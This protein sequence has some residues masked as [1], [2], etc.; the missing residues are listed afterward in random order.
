MD[1]FEEKLESGVKCSQSTSSKSLI[2][3]ISTGFNECGK[4]DIEPSNSE[5]ISENFTIKI[6]R[7]CSE[8]DIKINEN[9]IP[10]YSKL[11]ISK[12]KDS[13]L[14]KVDTG[15]GGDQTLIKECK[16]PVYKTHLC[17]ESYLSEFKSETEKK[18]ARNN[19]NVYSKEETHLII[20][21]SV[22]NIVTKNDLEEFIKD[23]DYTTSE[24]KMN[25][26][27]IIPDN[28]FK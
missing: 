5:N 13:I 28:L 9:I 12:N 7:D 26:N 20:Q 10:C 4:A 16:K 8:N 19:L 21:K 24:L 14:T 17:K 1:K 3:I 2:G 11:P 15:F 18:L 23:L 22:S 6:Q 27:Y 25:V